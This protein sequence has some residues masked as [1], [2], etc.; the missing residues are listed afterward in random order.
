MTGA[1]PWQR[2]PSVPASGQTAARARHLLTVAL[3]AEV[4]GIRCSTTSP[5]TPSC[6]VAVMYVQCGCRRRSVGEPGLSSRRPVAAVLSHGMWLWPNTS[7]SVCGI[8]SRHPLVA[9]GRGAGLVDDREPHPVQRRRRPSREAGPA[10]PGRRC[11]PNSR[12]AVPRAPAAHRAAT[13]STQSPACSTTSARST[14]SHSCR[15]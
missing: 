7:T 9:A 12:S 2:K 6:A 1:W 14:S 8:T 3:N 13:T 10:A 11:C 5:S 4:R 15:R